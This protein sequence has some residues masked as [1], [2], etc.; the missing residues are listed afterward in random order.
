MISGTNAIRI[1]KMQSNNSDHKRFSE[2]SHLLKARSNVSAVCFSDLLLWSSLA[3]PRDYQNCETA[4]DRCGE[5]PRDYVDQGQSGSG[6]RCRSGRGRCGNCHTGL[7]CGGSVGSF[8]CNCVIGA[9]WSVAAQG[10][11][12]G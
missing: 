8:D 7:V 2:K 11:G 4:C 10:D 1:S 6:Q 12:D 3:M 5:D 9:R